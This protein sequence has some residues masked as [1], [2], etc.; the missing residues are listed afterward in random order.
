MAQLTIVV[1]PT[2]DEV[3]EEAAGVAGALPLRFPE[4][5]LHPVRVRGYVQQV[6][7]WCAANPNAR[8]ALLTFS[9]AVVNAVGHLVREGKISADEVEIRGRRTLGTPFVAHYGPDGALRGWPYGFLSPT[10]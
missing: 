6:V 5:G 8:V 2:V 1:G 10:R 7:A 3:E 9:E 4:T